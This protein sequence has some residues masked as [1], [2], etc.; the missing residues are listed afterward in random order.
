MTCNEVAE[1]ELNAKKV[2]P[3]V[4]RENKGRVAHARARGLW[5]QSMN[6]RAGMY[7]M[8]LWPLSLLLFMFSTAFFL[9]FTSGITNPIN[10]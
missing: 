10:L 1:C 6:A 5:Y 7:L 2:A 4:M 8:R 9:L 3:T